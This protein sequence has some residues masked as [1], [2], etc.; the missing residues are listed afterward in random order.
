VTQPFRDDRAGADE[1]ADAPVIRD[2]RRIDPVTGKV[3]P[4]PGATS[5]GATAPGTTGK[6]GASAPG[7]PGAA[8][9]VPSA[10]AAEDEFTADALASEE[11]DRLQRLADERT[12][13]LQRLQAEYVNYR[14]RV[15]RDRAVA[16]DVATAKVIGELLPVLDDVDRADQHGEL[17]GG[18]KAV[19]DALFRAL[20]RVGVTRFG[21]VGEPFDPLVHEAL[22]HR[23]EAGLEGPTAT[24]ILQ[25]GYR[26]GE[27]V[28]RPARVVVS[29]PGGG[30][31]EAPGSDPDA[32]ESAGA[33]D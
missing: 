16:G 10:G 2:R 5:P 27:R 29:D 15:D 6:P 24:A 21:E 13:D 31:D 4:A 18:F 1:D 28:L 9:G 32:G 7:F 11:L 22:M 33:S 23:H 8:G 19:G 14:R 3:R 30:P 12:L 20:E 26:M 17:T 25:P